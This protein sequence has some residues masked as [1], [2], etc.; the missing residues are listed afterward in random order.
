M[1]FRPLPP[2]RNIVLNRPSSLMLDPTWSK[3]IILAT[4]V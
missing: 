3:A 4:S 1:P 2:C